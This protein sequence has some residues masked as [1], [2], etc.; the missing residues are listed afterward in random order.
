[1][2]NSQKHLGWNL[3]TKGSGKMGGGVCSSQDKG[4]WLKKI[5]TNFEFSQPIFRFL[6]DLSNLV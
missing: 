3:E 4:C 1:M 5:L 6:P 2:T